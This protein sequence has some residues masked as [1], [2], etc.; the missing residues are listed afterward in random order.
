MP[1]TPADVHN[2]AFSKPPIGKPG[3][4]EDE[5]DAFVDLIEAELTR[6][7]DDN[8]DLGN[9]LQGL[10]QRLHAA[11]ID[12]AANPRPVS[13][14]QPEMTPAHPPTR[15]PVGAG[16]D[17]NAHAAR[18]LG[19]AQQMANRLT[20]EAQAEA[21]GMLSDARLNAE[22]LL[23]Q[24][25]TKAEGL[26]TEASTRAKTMLE[27]ARAR[28]ETLEQQSRNTAAAQQQQAARQHTDIITALTEEKNALENRIKQL[29]AFERTCRTSLV[30][31]A[32]SQLHE[33]G[34]HQPPGPADPMDGRAQRSAAF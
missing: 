5:V 25:R 16:E 33:L 31:Y 11:C 24:A 15:E 20:G 21:D 29:R 12:T 14:A 3:Y 30:S 4:H 27:D 6:L 19:M 28:A 34:G 26:A 18:V 7:I 9:Q 1:L 22:Q 8:H 23:R 10:A 17:H 13:P 32:Q 2:V